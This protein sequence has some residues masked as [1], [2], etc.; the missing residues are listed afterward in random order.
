MLV[1]G[2]EQLFP[3]SVDERESVSHQRHV[4]NF[5]DVSD[6]IGDHHDA[7]ERQFGAFA[8]WFCAEAYHQVVGGCISRDLVQEIALVVLQVL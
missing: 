1:E 2:E 4:V 3:L 5:F 7:V 6:D 8:A